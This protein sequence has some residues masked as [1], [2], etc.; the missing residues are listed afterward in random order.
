MEKIKRSGGTAIIA[1]VIM[2][3]VVGW[4]TTLAHYHNAVG[5]KN[6]K[7]EMLKL[8]ALDSQ[9][10]VEQLL[11]ELKELKE[12][13]FKIYLAWRR[14]RKVELTASNFHKYYVG[15]EMAPFFR[16]D[17]RIEKLIRAYNEVYYPDY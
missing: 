10:K 17:E 8:Q 9:Y 13:I 7:I 15:I 16:L 5:E 12:P 6:D 3:L 2:C 4:V 1:V 14:T 11:G